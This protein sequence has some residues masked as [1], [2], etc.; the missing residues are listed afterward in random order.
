MIAG[1]TDTR[2]LV[3][4]LGQRRRRLVKTLMEWPW[5]QT[6]DTLRQRFRED[7][8]GLTAGS[9]TFTTTIALVPMLTVMLALFSAFPVFSHFRT[10]LEQQVLQ[11]LVPDL[12]ARPVVMS[13]NRFAAK[14]SQLGAMGLVGLGVSAMALMLTIDHTLNGIWRVR[15]VRPLPQRVL[16]Y[17]AAITLGPLLV[18]ASLSL[19]SYVLSAS[20]GLV[21]ELSGGVGF[22]LRLVVIALQAIG[23]AALY[24]Y[25]PNTFVRRE[26]AWVGAIL[27]TLALELAQHGLAL[28]LAQVRVYATIYGA[29]AAVPIFLVWIYLSWLIVLMGAVVAAYLPSLLSQVRRWPQTPSL[30]LSLALAVLGQLDSAKRSALRGTS[31]MGLAQAL[32]TDPL[33]IEPVLETLQSLDWIAAL[34][35]DDEALGARY[36]LLCEPEETALAPL[37]EQTLLSRDE[38]T[39][40]LWRQLL[41]SSLNLASVLPPH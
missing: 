35:E 16:V 3:D 8:L 28:Y 24:R 7:R 1:M 41:S 19:T 20:S 4:T 15:S 27:A 12:I 22:L 10:V 13:L 26:H 2:T 37:L 11:G 14:A 30:K 21:H 33:Q 36:V 5:R 25:V 38:F 34:R 32:R 23:F 29:F 6:Y 9:L 39:A 18:G 31:L 17:W 40:P